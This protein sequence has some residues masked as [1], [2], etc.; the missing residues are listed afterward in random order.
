MQSG[1][2]LNI[3]SLLTI[4]RIS[5]VHVAPNRKY[6]ALEINRIHENYDVFLFDLKSYG[7]IIPLTRTPDATFITDWTPDSKSVIVGEDSAGDERVTLY[8]VDIDSPFE[9]QSL[10][11][12]HPPNFMRGGYCSP[13]NDF[14]AYAANYDYD[15]RKVTETFRIIVQDLESGKRTIVAR[16][17]K[18][19]YATLSIHPKGKYILYSRSDENPAG[20]QWWS[21]TPQGD[22][23]REVLNFGATAKVSA[24]WTF[25]GRIA[26]STDTIDGERYDS[27]AIGIYDTVSEKIQWLVMPSDEELYDDVSIPKHSHHA[28]LVRE[29]EGRRR[30]TIYDLEHDTQIECTPL[31]GNLWPVTPLALNQWLGYYYSSTS[32]LNLVL[33]NPFSPIIKEFEY[34]TDMLAASGLCADDL[35]PAEEHRWISVDN[36]MIHGWLY[37]PKYSNGRTIVKIHG[38][39]TAHSEDALSVDIQYF[40]SL[41]YTILDPNYRGSTGYGVNFREL[42]KKDGWGGKDLEDIRAGIHS[43]FENGIANPNRIG[44]YGT[45]YGGYMSWNAI[46]HFNRQEIAAAAPI[47][48]MTDLV[49]DYE[50]TR[51]DLRPYSEEM[52]GG[53]PT[54]IPEKYYERSPINFVKNIKGKVLIIQGLRDPNVTRTNVEEIEKRL[55]EYNISFE[56][57]VFEDEGHGIIR[58]ENVKILLKRISEF[59]ELSL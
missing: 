55:N 46:V 59:F 50:T 12:K 21:V 22:Q 9:M 53:S 33:F 7:N 45:S 1:K 43:L 37:R 20:V 3:D 24:N 47:C 4:P 25:D 31:N 42:I 36:T 38:G 26:F 14:I 10:T 35:I 54:D 15:T 48:G 39:P 44:I 27:V 19:N 34:L 5:S 16:P 32:P 29:R 13:N 6:V 23:D 30:A 52:L 40:C 28:L 51:P 2:F 11:Q 8:K 57:L 58:E 17:D 56:K 18:P 41:G 49:I